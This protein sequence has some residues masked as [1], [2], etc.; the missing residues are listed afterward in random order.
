MLCS[1]SVRNVLLISRLDIEFGEGLNVLTGETGAGKSILLDS[2]GFVLGRVALQK[3]LAAGGEPSEVSASVDI[4]GN[5]LARSVLDDLDISAGNDLLIRRVVLASGRTSSFVND[6]RCT[7]EAVG[8]IGDTIV[9]VHG[10]SDERWL[11]SAAFH[12]RLLDQFAGHDELVLRTRQSWQDWQVERRQLQTARS[13]LEIAAREREYT[14]HAARELEE[15]SPMAGEDAEL[16]NRR[17]VLKLFSR[18]QEN[19]AKAESA[20]GSEGADG[21]INEALRWL[22]SASPIDEERIGRIVGSL[23]RALSE[24]SEAQ[25]LLDD[26]RRGIDYEPLEIEQVEE[27]LFAIRALARKHSVHPDELGEVTL[28]LTADL[29]RLD[30]LQDEVDRL[31]KSNSIKQDEYVGFAEDLSNGRTSAAKLLD[32]AMA[33]EVKPLRLHN[34]RF[35]AVLSDDGPGPEG[36]NRVSFTVST[37]PSMPP[38]PISQIAS[39]GEL[40]RFMLALK[41]CLMAD[42]QEVCAIFDEIDRGIGGA[43]ANAVG[44]RLRTLAEQSQVLVVTHS[45]QVAAM[46]HHHWRIEKVTDQEHVQTRAHRLAGDSRRDEIARMLSG[47]NVTDE[48]RAAAIALLQA[49]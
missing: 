29:G 26:I 32:A 11:A 20:T 41:V 30:H 16:D 48:A 25:R 15:L 42:T 46:G 2:L 8:R 3:Q 18:F 9:E 24:L 5:Q 45:P 4:S 49:V 23:D 37:N 31:E 39:G 35:E 47:E 13:E 6:Q 36:K 43:T 22:E 44:R 33:R 38:G 12:R 7:V 17:S 14:E 21:M 27:R 19:L 34:T 10:Q 40:S 28:K 1:L